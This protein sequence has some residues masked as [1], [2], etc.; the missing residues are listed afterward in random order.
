MQTSRQKEL[1]GLTTQVQNKGHQLRELCQKQHA[2]VKDKKIAFVELLGL[3]ETTLNYAYFLQ[4]WLEQSE[5]KLGE[6]EVTQR[7]LKEFEREQMLRSVPPIIIH[8]LR[9]TRPL[10][11]K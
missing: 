9:P 11:W 4:E 3:C 7:R 5:E 10:V 2:A 8:S 1:K 6:L